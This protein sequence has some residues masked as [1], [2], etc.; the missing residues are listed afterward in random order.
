MSTHR[1]RFTVRHVEYLLAGVL[2]LGPAALADRGAIVSVGKVDLAEPAQRAIIV[3]DGAQELLILQTD[4]QADKETKV[5]EFMPLP[6]EPAVSLAPDGCFAALQR[7]VKDHNLR[8]VVKLKGAA[9]DRQAEQAIDVVTT[10]QLG[11]HAVTVVKVNDAVEFVGWVRAFFE[12][13][14]LGEPAMGDNLQEIVGDYLARNLK[15]F[16]FDIVTLSPEKKTIQPLA[17]EFA[18]DHLYYPLKVTN[19]YGGSGTIELFFILPRLV[20]GPVEDI[21]IRPSSTPEWDSHPGFRR[22]SDALVSPNNLQF[23]HPRI[24]KLVGHELGWLFAVKYEGPLAFD[25]DLWVGD[26]HVYAPYAP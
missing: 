10:A 8:Y 4:V 21:R 14:D 19:L 26:W 11:P 20:S 2:L 16:A 23:L 24:P 13:N 7:I 12:K 3:F 1:C 15:Y 18:S 5:V 25:H 22:S 17:Y 6:S 9:G